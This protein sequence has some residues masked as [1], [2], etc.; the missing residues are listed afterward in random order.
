MAGLLEAVYRA[1]LLGLETPIRRAQ[2]SSGSGFSTAVALSAG[3]APRPMSG[4]FAGLI[5][6]SILG[7]GRCSWFLGS[8]R[9]RGKLRRRARY[10]SVL[11]ATN[12]AWSISVSSSIASAMGVARIPTHGSW[13]P[14]VSTVVALPSLSMERRAEAN[15]RSGFDRN[16]H[17]DVLTGGK[18]HREFLPHY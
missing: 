3:F 11:G 14:C 17:H 7:G 6:R 12:N 9:S 10:V 1:V 4:Y 15:T 2:A 8:W 13:R 18:S 5:C 16:F